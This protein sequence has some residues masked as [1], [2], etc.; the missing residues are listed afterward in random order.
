VVSPV[1]VLLVDDDPLVRSGLRMLLSRAPSV[2]VVAEAGDGREALAELDRHKTD[3]VLMDLRMPQLD[4]IAA[5]RLV[6][7]RPDPPAVVVLTTFDAD[8]L[9]VGALEAG[10]AGFLLKHAPPGD[11]V[12]AIETIGAGESMLSPEITRRLIAMVTGGGGRRAAARD[13][14]ARLTPREAEVADAVARGLSNTEIARELYMS[15]GTVKVHVTRLFAKLEV[16]NRV[17]IALLVND[18]R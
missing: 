7:A 5:T 8:E 3:V 18:A 16:D 17:Q 12:R 15:V 9:V 10:A 11:I 4:G 14:L 6:R 13:Q 1:R 2:E